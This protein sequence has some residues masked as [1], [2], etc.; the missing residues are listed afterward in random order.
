[1]VT[2][3]RSRGHGAL[4]SRIARRVRPALLFLVPL[5]LLVSLVSGTVAGAVAG[6]SAT[7][8]RTGSERS[9]PARPM[10]VPQGSRAEPTDPPL[11][12]PA[13][14]AAE[15]RKVTLSST[16]AGGLSAGLLVG[17]ARPAATGAASPTAGSVVRIGPAP[18]KARGSVARAGGGGAAPSS[19]TVRMLEHAKVARLGAQGVATVI[20]RSDGVARAAPVRVSLSYAGFADAHG[21]DYGARL[22]LATMPACAL[23]TPKV[24]RC[25]TPTLI[26]NAS[27]SVAKSTVTGT[28]QANPD[29]AAKPANGNGGQIVM[30]VAG[31][32]STSG[33]YRATGLPQSGTWSSGPGSGDFNYSVPVS[34]PP[35]P[36]GTTPT[37]SLNYDSQSVDGMTSAMNTQGGL[38]GLGWDLN[39]AYIERE[40]RT[41]SND[42]AASS[43]GDLC[44]HSPAPAA[45]D[46]PGGAVYDIVLNGVS[47]VLVP[48]PTVAGEYHLTDD[49]GWLVQHLTGASNGAA[50]GEYWVVSTP[51]GTRYYFGYGKRVS[52]GTATNSVLTVPVFGNNPGEPCYSTGTLSPCT[53]AWRWYL[54]RSI[55]V[56]EV[57]TSYM[58]KVETNNYYSTMGANKERSYDSAGDLTEID[59]GYAEQLPNPAFTDEVDFDVVGRC[60]D[61]NSQTD[62]LHSTVADCPSLTNDPS[63]YPDVPTDLICPAGDSSNCSTYSDAPVFFTTEMLWSMTTYTLSPTGAK[64]EV[65]DYQLKHDLTNAPGDV[66]TFL[67]FDYLQ[68]EGF[69]GTGA[70]VTLPTTNFNGSYYDNTVSPSTTLN[71]KRITTIDTDTGG[72]ISISYGLPDACT[73]GS[74]MPAASNTQDCFDQSW[75]PQGDS[76]P[77]WNWFDKYMVTEVDSDPSVG[78]GPSHDGDPVQTTSYAYTANGAGWTFP[79]DPTPIWADSSWNVWRGYKSA[80][81]TS[82]SGSTLHSIAYWIFQG[83]DGDRTDVDGSTTK[84]VTVTGSPA[85]PAISYTDSPWLAGR[86]Y[87]ESDRDSTGLSQKYIVHDYGFVHTTAPYAG[88]PDA[89]FVSENQTYTYQR[90]SASTSAVSTWRESLTQ[91]MFDTSN[92]VTA[93]FGLPVASENDGQVGAAD[94][95]CTT[96]GYALHDSGAIDTAGVQWRIALPDDVRHYSDT[97]ANAS[98]SNQDGETVTL[99]DG[100]TSEAANAPYDGNPTEVDTYTSASAFEKKTS[101]FDAAGR[102]LTST[103]GDGNTTT[104]SYSPASGWPAGGVQVST[105]VPDISADDYTGHTGSA[106][107][108]VTTT[109]SSPATGQPLTVTDPNGLVTTSQYDTAGRLISVWKPKDPT[110]GSASIKYTYTL[111]AATSGTVPG[112]VDGPPEVETQTLQSGSTYLPA[113]TYYDGLGQVREQQTPAADGSAGRDVVSTRYDVA[114]FVEGTSAPYDNSS[115]PGSGMVNPAVASLPAYHDPVLDWAGRTTLAQVEAYGVSQP[116][117]KVTTQYWPDETVATDA[118]GNVTTTSLDVFGNT[119][120]IV[121]ST[122][123]LSPASVTTTYG[124]DD[125]N[126]LTKVTDSAGNVTSY[127]LNW[128]GQQTAAVDPDAGRSCTY[129]DGN[130][131]VQYTDAS[132]P[133]T[134]P[135]DPTTLASRITTVYDALNR[136][137]STWQGTVGAGTELASDTYD[138][139][140]LGKDKPATSTSYAGTSAY[141]SSVDGYDGDGD[142]LGTTTKVPGSE[143]A[144]AGSYDTTATYNSAGNRLTTGYPAAGTGAAALPAET[145]TTTYGSTGLPAKLAGSVNYVTGTTYTNWGPISSRSYGG[146]V[147]T[148]AATRSYS[149][150]QATGWL[151]GIQTGVTN[152][153]TQTTAQND[154]YGYDDAGNIT[155]IASAA[156]TAQQ[157]CFSYDALDRLTS[158]F[159]TTAAAAPASTVASCGSATASHSGGPSPYDLAYTY[160]QLGSITSVADNIGGSTAAYSYPANGAASPDQPHGVTAV[161]HTATASGSV[162]GTDSYGYAGDGDMTSSSVGG[163]AATMTWNPQQLL[164]SVSGGGNTT[165]YVYD[166][167]GNLLVRHGPASTTL[168]LPGEDLNLTGTTVTPTRYY[169]IGGATV[170]MRVGGSNGSTGTLTWLTADALDSSQVAINASTGTYTQQR[171]T[172]YGAQRGTQGPTAGTQHGFLG[173]PYD[174]STALVQDGARFYNPSLGAFVSPDPVVA[175]TDPQNLNAYTYAA[176]NPETESDPSG[177]HPLYCPPSEDCSPSNDHNDGP[178]PTGDMG[179]GSSPSGPSTTSTGKGTSPVTV[180]KTSAGLIV[181]LGDPS[182][183]SSGTDPNVWVCVAGTI[184]K[185]HPGYDPV[186]VLGDVSPAG[187]LCLVDNGE[188]ASPHFANPLLFGNQVPQ[189]DI[190]LM[191]VNA[192]TDIP[193]PGNHMAGGAA[194]G[195]VVLGAASWGAA[196]L[197]ECVSADLTIG[198]VGGGIALGAALGGWAGAHSYPAASTAQ[199]PD[200]TRYF[201]LR[202]GQHESTQQAWCTIYGPGGHVNGC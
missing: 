138:T 27:N 199:T 151:T 61:R 40:Y 26:A 93:L 156:G 96:Y 78:T 21:G 8:R 29:P 147:S 149:W 72:V 42:G 22:R 82:G 145:V 136:P 46:D 150:D 186:C 98:A 181:L 100:A 66:G 202:L 115:A 90:A 2:S 80:T 126:R 166:A 143:G 123:H 38:V 34:V 24:A 157:Q 91:Q 154:T 177:L 195:A 23:S 132:A 134:C 137:T 71:F 161:Q 7:V 51:D 30:L 120:S 52:D 127:T 94:N 111:P 159:T 173:H 107:P 146:A 102:V 196:C 79:S 35:A 88:L 84:S 140:A 185:V 171:Y 25:S 144:L 19:V 64:A 194:A 12:R 74:E 141:T 4:A 48:D 75:I 193:Q 15:T 153:S 104:T 117:Q 125:M 67:W 62:P 13:W 97:C 197:P 187:S 164:S 131:N 85:G 101:T 192:G 14:P 200:Q 57:D 139:A 81:V 183:P 59:Y 76:S 86:V 133:A 60:T 32:S 1:V 116:T 20:D 152:G 179:G 148:I 16:A 53:Q 65:T 56:Q 50:N 142:A 95:S 89:R 114:G 119:T 41:C 77:Q 118:D 190:G 170:A 45:S 122:P 92:P 174:P 68:R 105:P 113:Y 172:P 178:T 106:T 33:D 55:S 162:T 10:G 49:N 121:Q 6:A 18:A 37:V 31:T 3:S 182:D 28:V 198:A 168:Y 69:S 109:V 112:V 128:T 163:T 158:A 83:L 87:E 175:A 44:W 73:A 110:S 180:L 43:V 70:D 36:Y 155:E 184:C 167:A 201:G 99:Y 103:D 135:P 47:S 191:T 189:G 130:G 160:N 17:L 188:A 54:D 58:Y 63:D 129:Y 5:A 39:S 165:S 9:V 11:G 108:L 169:V 176:G 124:Y